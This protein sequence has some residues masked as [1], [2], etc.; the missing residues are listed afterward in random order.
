MNFTAVGLE[1]PPPHRPPHAKGTSNTSSALPPLLPVNAEIPTPP[2][3]DIDDLVSLSSRSPR[4]VSW[5]HLDK[6]QQQPTQVASW[7]LTFAPGS[8]KRGQAD[9]V[10]EIDSCSPISP[11]V[12]KVH[13]RTRLVDDSRTRPALLQELQIFLHAE[14]DGGGK[15][16]SEAKS[17]PS[18]R[19]LQV[20]RE[21]LGRLIAGFSVYAPV[22]TRI[23]DEYENAVESLHA[24][25]L[26]VPGLQT[27]L[28]SVETH[29]LR[30][31]ST[32]NVEAKARSLK[33]KR[34]LADTQALVAASAAENARLTAALG[35]EKEKA[36]HVESKLAEFQRST[37]ALTNSVRRHDES[38]RAGH[39]RS[40]EDAR[41]LQRVTARYY[42]ACDE[43]AELKQTVAAL[44]EQ[45]NGEHVAADK[46]TIALLTREIQ[47][48]SKALATAGSARQPKSAL[49]QQEENESSHVALNHAFVRALDTFGVTLKLSELLT[50]IAKAVTIP[51][52]IDG[53]AEIIVR[54]LRQAQQ[55]Q[56]ALLAPKIEPGGDQQSPLIFLTEPAELLD[57]N[58]ATAEQIVTSGIPSTSMS[59]DFLPGRGLSEDVPQYLQHDGIVRNLFLPRVKIEQLVSQ[60]WDQLDELVRATH[61]RGAGRAA[62]SSSNETALSSSNG[63]SALEMALE[64]CMQRA[65]DNRADRTELAYNFLDGLE[66]FNKQSS[67]CRLFHLVF[68]E[69]LPIEVRGDQARELSRLYDALVVVD[70][71]RHFADSTSSGEEANLSAIPLPPGRV[72]LADV[73]RTLRLTF[74]WKSDAAL[75]QLHRALL[76]DMR[77]QPQVDYAALLTSAPHSNA[78]TGAKPAGVR[79]K[80]AHP[81]WQFSECLKMQRLDD[82]LAFR[83]HLQHQIRRRLQTEEMKPNEL[84]EDDSEAQMITLH[85][86]RD[87]LQKADPAMTEQDLTRILVGLSGLSVRELLTHDDMVLDARQVLRRLPTMLL[88]PASRFNSEQ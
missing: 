4:S 69:E 37:L 76:A 31:L 10:L 85:D 71:D 59:G 53:T 44:E 50:S 41:A 55:L 6:T 61:N 64:R 49:T 83:H 86:V 65:R 25:S 77:G 88:R 35:V 34:R 17:T 19:R 52:G 43:L 15:E 3:R 14:L 58:A 22:L 57:F 16:S 56:F 2:R 8:P 62:A 40:L 9:T 28:Q 84:P 87:C 72:S 32:C 67:T 23:R 29:C 51:E 26:M 78:G 54:K 75:S 81:K 48:L 42:H 74:P 46:N 47:D 1:N 63:G 5:L 45:G 70:R 68:N 80:Q 39:E 24:K 18:L 21:A 79:S 13:T 11:K 73:V 60:V 27:R 38:L 66:R 12:R 7:P 82:L 33:L 30:Q 36:A 20:A